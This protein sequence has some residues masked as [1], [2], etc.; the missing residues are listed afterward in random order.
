[1]NDEQKNTM[2]AAGAVAVPI[3]FGV[4]RLS[5]LATKYNH[6]KIDKV[7]HDQSLVKNKSALNKIAKQN[8]IKILRGSIISM[9]NSYAL[10]GRNI[11]TVF[12]NK[13]VPG[14]LKGLARLRGFKP[15]RNTIVV[16]PKGIDAITAHELGH[17]MDYNSFPFKYKFNPLFK[18]N[19]RLL[20]YGE[21]ISYDKHS[22]KKDK[23]TRKNLIGVPINLLTGAY[24]SNKLA[25]GEKLDTKDKVLMA[26]VGAYDFLPEAALARSEATASVRGMNLLRKA[27]KKMK[28]SQRIPYLAR[29]AKALAHAFGTYAGGIG[30]S[31]ALTGAGLGAGTFIGT[32]LSKDYINDDTYYVLKDIDSKPILLNYFSNKDS[33]LKYKN[34]TSN[35]YIN[36]GSTLK[37]KGYRKLSDLR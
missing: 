33:A 34:D 37:S 21:G 8:N 17:I 1:M 26:G 25:K 35:S 9:G 14:I 5:R 20:Q 3:G 11:K 22:F 12:D 29:S 27:S 30:T 13:K 36:L 2:I 18:A 10:D 24:I 7:F 6:N 31:L 19:K 28:L 4:D 32:T 15:G 16:H 23:S